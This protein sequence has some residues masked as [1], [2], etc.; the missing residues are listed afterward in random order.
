MFEI[1]G[2]GSCMFVEDRENL[3]ELF[4]KDV[5]VIPYENIE[6]LILKIK[7]YSNKMDKIEKVAEKGYIKTINNHTTFH[8]VLKIHN[9]IEKLLN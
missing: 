7:F 6:D 5:E 1:T 2:C 8:R 3:E 4:K 9:K